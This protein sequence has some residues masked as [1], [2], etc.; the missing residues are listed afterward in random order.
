MLLANSFTGGS[1]GAT[2]TT[3]NS[4]GTSGNAFTTAIGDASYSTSWATGSRSPRTA[5]MP[6]NGFFSSLAWSFSLAARTFY[7]RTYLR[8]SWLPSAGG[9]IA[10]RSIFSATG[11]AVTLNDAGTLRLV[12]TTNSATLLTL[13]DEIPAEQWV[14]V[15]LRVT[16]GTTTSNGTA[17]LRLYL[18]ADTAVASD[19]VSATGLN[20]GTT[21]TTTAVW[22]TLDLVEHY[23]DDLAI[24]DVDWI[25]S[26]SVSQE[27]EPATVVG[28]WDV[29]APALSAGVTAAPETVVGSWSVPTPD[30]L[31]LEGGAPA[32]AQPDLIEAS[33]SVPAP[34]AQA[35]KNVEVSP[36]TVV[37]RWE[38]P[39]PA[40]GGST[41]PG[42]QITRAGQIE[43]NGYLLG[44]G[45]FVRLKTLDG[46]Y[47]LPDLDSGNVPHPTRDGA[48]SGRPLAQERYVIFG[49]S[50]NA[51]LD[52]WEDVIEELRLRTG[53]SVDDTEYPLAIRVL[54]RIWIGYGQVTRRPI[55]VN[56]AFRMGLANVTIRWTLS[57]PRLLSRE[58]ANAVIADGATA[59]LANVGNT[60]AYP[61]IRVPGPANDPQLL[62]EQYIGSE[63]VDE[64]LLEF[65][66]SLGSGERLTIDTKLGIASVGGEDVS[67]S[68]TQTSA[69]VSD[70]VFPPGSVDFSYTSAG[71]SSPDATVLWR[72]AVL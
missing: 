30:V 6:N 56:Q 50:A 33:W 49:G 7:M 22:P 26:T 38:V 27:A 12:N 31:A 25:G 57:D 71:A 63:V 14:R 39:Q 68:L 35:F 11:I 43:W 59:T 23:L 67:S 62:I 44:S 55:P 36:A 8:M 24:T 70:F 58:L 19:T 65:D 3:G 45:T 9:S 34:V 54:E 37:G 5:L 51:P 4:G 2:I 69:P 48:Y 29:P 53:K 15:E 66:L 13:G 46:W 52:V 47:D 10:E 61:E 64:K 16:Y 42:G 32:H 40:V 41:V 1:P 17:E 20:T 18:A 28:T 72:H 21:V 60:W